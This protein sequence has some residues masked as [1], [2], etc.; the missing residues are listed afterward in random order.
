MSLADK[1]SGVVDQPTA[2]EAKYRP[3][4]EFDGAT[5]YILTEPLEDPPADHTA[6]LERFGYDPDKYTI[7]GDQHQ[8]TR[9][10]GYDGR[11]L[12]RYRF[13]VALRTATLD[14]DELL[15]DVGKW[16]PRTPAPIMGDG[17][18]VFQASDLQLGKIDGDGLEGTVE[19]YRVSVDRAVADLKRL[20]KACGITA[21]HLIFAGDCIENG[22]V[23]QGGKSAWRQSLTVTEQVRVWR[24]LLL[25]TVKAFASLSEACFVSVV[26]GN[27][28]DA[29]R[30]PVMTRADDNWATE[31]AIAV[32]DTLAEVG[33]FD[34]IRVQVPPRDQGFMTV[35]VNE[36]V[37]TITHGHQWRKGKAADWWASQAFYQGNPAG[38][39][40]L[41]HGHWHSTSIAQDG[42][43]TVICSPTFDGGSSWYRDKTG[44][45][46]RQGG[47][48]YV[49]HGPEFSH[50]GV[51]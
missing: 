16:K 25:S 32:A 6:L 21:V 49:T 8:T 23:A 36:S 18:F 33:G 19:R 20:R 17:V 5:G 27:Q 13:N 43:R 11:W 50:L 44:A 14:L 29:T 42:P 26:G 10:Q 46:A 9:W 45:E 7:V 2:K 34:H 4:T 22:G 15:A 12:S 24:R 38:A 40:F 39:H 51:V 31:G 48:V 41:C 37:F 47:L 35:K 1:L 3:F 30:M 28:D